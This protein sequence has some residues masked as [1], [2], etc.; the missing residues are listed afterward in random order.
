MFE[1]LLH[2]FLTF[3]NKGFPNSALYVKGV[4]RVFFL[5]QKKLKSKASFLSEKNTKEFP[6]EN[7][8]VRS[9]L[10]KSFVFHWFLCPPAKKSIGLVYPQF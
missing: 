3:Y 1:N 8:R 6:I 9:D 2:Y 10:Q 7:F 5:S 4:I